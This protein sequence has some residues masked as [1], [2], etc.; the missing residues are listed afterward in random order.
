ML[1]FDEPAWGPPEAP[2][3]EFLQYLHKI[4]E[5]NVP[6]ATSPISSASIIPA[7]FGH[8]HLH[9]LAALLVHKGS[10][11]KNPAL[12]THFG[13]VGARDRG[14]ALQGAAVPPPRRG[15]D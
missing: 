5:P 6:L 15:G 9:V 2:S 1:L 13:D 3:A 7:R 12:T 4:L 10:K 14:V 8:G 11:G